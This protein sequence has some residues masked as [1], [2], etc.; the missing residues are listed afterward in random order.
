VQKEEEE[1][2][3]RHSTTSGGDEWCCHLRQRTL[4]ASV[5]SS[6]RYIADMR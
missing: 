5:V 4:P 3:Q 6:G 1:H 2:G